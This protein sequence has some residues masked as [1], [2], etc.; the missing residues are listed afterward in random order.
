MPYVYL[1]IVQYAFVRMRICMHTH[2]PYVIFCLHTLMLS[3][4]N[5]TDCPLEALSFLSTIITI[6]MYT[7]HHT[8]S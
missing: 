8:K 2:M 6:E 3:D 5:I 1:Y 4:T 7:L